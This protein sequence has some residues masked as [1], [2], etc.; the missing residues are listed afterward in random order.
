MSCQG[1]LVMGRYY[2]VC[3]RNKP[4]DNSTWDRWKQR[5]LSFGQ[6]LV[7]ERMLEIRGVREVGLI[8]E[9][10]HRIRQGTSK[11]H[12]PSK[13]RDPL[14]VMMGSRNSGAVFRPCFW[15]GTRS[16]VNGQPKVCG[17]KEEYRAENGL[18]GKNERWSQAFILLIKNW[19]NMDHSHRNYFQGIHMKVNFWILHFLIS[20]SM[21]CK[22]CTYI[23]LFQ[24]YDIC[25]FPALWKSFL[26]FHIWIEIHHETNYFS[27]L[28]YEPNF[29]GLV[30]LSDSITQNDAILKLWPCY[31][32]LPTVFM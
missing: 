20:H 10:Q 25:I 15:Q 12:W 26:L 32:C 27:Q 7:V 23:I 8:E 18:G 5:S 30:Y 1:F 6:V 29:A 11:P 4:T 24:K 17:D 19:I 9:N 21:Q 2:Q 22:T 14:S 31:I 28:T 16:D 3:C 13:I